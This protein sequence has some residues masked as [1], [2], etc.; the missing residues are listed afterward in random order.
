VGTSLLVPLG[1]CLVAD[2]CAETILQWSGFLFQMIALGMAAYEINQL[3][4]KVFSGP[5]FLNRMGWRRHTH[6]LSLDDITIETSMGSFGLTVL[7]PPTTDVDQR[8]RRLEAK[9]LELDQADR[10]LGEELEAE[11]HQRKKAFG[12]IKDEFTRELN[13]AEERLKEATLGSDLERVYAALI[14]G[15][16]GTVFS[17]FSEC[18]GGWF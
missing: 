9:V 16:V 3:D 11:K 18:I 2:A 10:R 7:E 8:L 4:V 14:L 15:L 5:G 12:E 13:T 17:T 6:H 1:L